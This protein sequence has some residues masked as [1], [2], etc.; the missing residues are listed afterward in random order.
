MGCGI[1]RPAY[2]PIVAVEPVAP[3]GV[4]TPA[5]VAVG[6][7]VSINTGWDAPA[8]VVRENVCV[9]RTVNVRQNVTRR[10]YGRGGARAV[11]RRGMGRE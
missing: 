5:A 9:N 4:Y 6:P 3:V 2:E 11:G 7:S 8:G 10:G 1:S